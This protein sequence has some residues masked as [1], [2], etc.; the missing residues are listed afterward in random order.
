MDA[1]F[2]SKP[3]QKFINMVMVQD[4]KSIA[5]RI[6]YGAMDSAS[7]KLKVEN[8]LVLFQKAL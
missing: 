5:E 7:E 3:V 1:R 6:V 8:P 2:K 4:K